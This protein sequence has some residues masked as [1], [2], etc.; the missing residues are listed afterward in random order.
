[1]K[2]W[3]KLLWHFGGLALIVSGAG[4]LAGIPGILL[5]VGLWAVL[6]TIFDTAMGI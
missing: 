1:M 5:A 3:V 2:P 6:A 4:M